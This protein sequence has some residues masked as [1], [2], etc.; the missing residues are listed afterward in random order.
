MGQP[1]APVP[2]TPVA[3]WLAP[4]IQVATQFGVSTVFAGILLW[5]VLTKMTSVLYSIE[6]WEEERTRVLNA[7]QAQ[8]MA[9]LEKQSASFEKA[10]QMNIEANQRLA[11]RYYGPSARP[12]LAHQ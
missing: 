1:A 8:I 12:P 4:L 9:A 2:V 10:I 7:S 6:K 5:F 3:G 11:D